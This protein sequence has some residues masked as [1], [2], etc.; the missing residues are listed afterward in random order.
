MMQVI[1]TLFSFEV[2]HL[3]LL[4]LLPNEILGRFEGLI[5]LA[6]YVYSIYLILL[7]IHKKFFGIWSL[8]ASHGQCQN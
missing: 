5:P 8:R 7:K 4:Y 1:V 2:F 6:T 3:Q